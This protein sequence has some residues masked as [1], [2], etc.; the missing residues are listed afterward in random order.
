MPADAWLAAGQPTQLPAGSLVSIVGAHRS[1]SSLPDGTIPPFRVFVLDTNG[2]LW[3]SAKV[4]TGGAPVWTSCGTP[5]SDVHCASGVGSTSYA[6]NRNSPPPGQPRPTVTG[7]FVIGSDGHLWVRVIDNTTQAVRWMDHGTPPGRRLAAG[8]QPSFLSAVLSPP[9]IITLAQD[10]HLWWRQPPLI[11][12]AETPLS[13]WTWTDLGSPTGQLIFAPVGTAPLNPAAAAVITD[14]GHLWII[15]LRDGVWTDL[16]TPAPT[17]TVASAVGMRVRQINNPDG[18]QRNEIHMFV[19]SAPN[20]GLRMCRW[21]PGEPARWTASDTLTPTIAPVHSIVG[22]GIHPADHARNVV[23]VLGRDDQ[24]HVL[25]PETGA[26]ERWLKPPP[27]I[28]LATAAMTVSLNPPPLTLYGLDDNG[29][30]HV[31]VG[32][33]G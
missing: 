17:E 22:V 10:G 27:Q 18:T 16:G 4:D 32:R 19:I 26:T 13:E 21:R 30:L 12:S 20:E 5:R 11:S 9:S 8:L 24:F 31:A 1:D 33:L 15:T 7:A 3:L 25:Q 6:A 2:G 29:L 23:C 14:N 28:R